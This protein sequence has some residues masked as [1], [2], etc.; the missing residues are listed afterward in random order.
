[1][2]AG[3]PVNGSAFLNQ[4]PIALPS[5][6]TIP[7]E[8][9]FQFALQGRPDLVHN[10]MVTVSVEASFT[11]VSIGYG[12]VPDVPPLKFGFLPR[13]VA[14]ATTTSAPA[15]T[16]VTALTRFL[17]RPVWQ[18][19]ATLDAALPTFPLS[20]LMG[21]LSGLGKT[22]LRVS[23]SVA[24]AAASVSSTATTPPATLAELQSRVQSVGPE[25]F[26]TAVVSA[27][28]EKLGE[29]QDLA[30]GTIGPR[31]AALLQNGIRVNPVF[32]D[33]IVRALSTGS[34]LDPK[35]LE[36]AFE[37]VAAPP[38][39]I[40]FKYALFDDGTGREFQSEP[41][42]N[43]AGLGAAD[44]RR[45]F[46][47]FARPIEFERRTAVRMQVIEVSG[48]R[49]QLHVTLQ[50]YKTLGTPGTPTGPR[51]ASRRLRRPA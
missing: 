24:G 19:I 2:S 11:A 17:Q 28:A 51:L 26:S 44:G 39:R 14:A 33:E 41:I 38:E 31:T 13:P 25:L 29:Q 15:T 1:M 12:V 16:A 23:P 42:L 50:G 37:A 46:R 8:Y 43:T 7:F 4:A 20:R 18:E 35:I 49:G 32:F 5:R 30:T 3:R 21:G 34:R 47:Y 9:S 45:P 22:A 40:Q 6:R 36:E 27:A 48:F 10:S